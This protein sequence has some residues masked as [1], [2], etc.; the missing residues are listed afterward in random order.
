LGELRPQA[1]FARK[2]IRELLELV[3][4]ALDFLIGCH[5]LVGGSSPVRVRQIRE[6]ARRETI[7]ASAPKA[8]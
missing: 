5:F 3:R 4:R 2:L 1:A 7:V 6:A 8:P